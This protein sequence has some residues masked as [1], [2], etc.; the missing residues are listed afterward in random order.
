MANTTNMAP[1]HPNDDDGIPP[2]P[3]EIL[4]QDPARIH[5][6][7]IPSYGHVQKCDCCNARAP[8]GI[9]QICNDCSLRLCRDCIEKRSWYRNRDHFVDSAK[10]DWR[11]QKAAMY[12]NGGRRKTATERRRYKAKRRRRMEDESDDDEEEESNAPTQRPLPPAPP[13]LSNQPTEN[14]ARAIAAG[15]LL[16]IREEC[17]RPSASSAVLAPA[18]GPFGCRLAEEEAE[19]SSLISD[20]YYWTYG[21]RPH[22]DPRRPRTQIPVT[23]SEPSG[24]HGPRDAASLTEAPGRPT[25]SLKFLLTSRP[26]KFKSWTDMF[27]FPGRRD[28]LQR[29]KQQ[30]RPLS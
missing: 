2:P 17:T 14:D 23:A 9:L 5:R 27:S 22:L 20:I 8:G 19:R 26:F 21:D 6:S 16:S 15:A 4:A 3:L 11:K 29:W 28:F 24:Y 25:V 10:C 18:L 12:G 30:S 13:A 7:W 1:A